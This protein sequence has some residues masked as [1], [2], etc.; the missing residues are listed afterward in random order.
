[1]TREQM[2][3]VLIGAG[4]DAEDFDDATDAEVRSFYLNRFD[5]QSA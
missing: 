4:Y 1:M 2:V 5:D 3:S